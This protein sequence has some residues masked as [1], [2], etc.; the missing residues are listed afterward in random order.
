M[1]AAGHYGI[2]YALQV[3]NALIKFLA[4]INILREN[5]A[6][7][8]AAIKPHELEHANNFHC[9]FRIAADG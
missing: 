9:V 4:L 7:H 6:T 1:D 2:I 3:D 5:H 8:S